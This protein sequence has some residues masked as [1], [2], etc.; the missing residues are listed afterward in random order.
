MVFKGKRAEKLNCSFPE[1][2]FPLTSA[3]NLYNLSFFNAFFCSKLHDSMKLTATS[4]STFCVVNISQ[5][6]VLRAHFKRKAAVLITPTSGTLLSSTKHAAH[7]SATF[8]SETHTGCSLLQLTWPPLLKSYFAVF[9]FHISPYTPLQELDCNYLSPE[10]RPTPSD[11]LAGLWSAGKEGASP[12]RHTNLIVVLPSAVFCKGA[13]P[14][15]VLLYR[16]EAKHSSVSP[17]WGW[18]NFF[19]YPHGLCIEGFMISLMH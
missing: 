14:E 19:F 15:S 13:Q 7:I 9:H 11:S 8:S 4:S 5:A 16:M 6:T 12:K 2:S 3:Y 10:D 18:M 1:L 17:F